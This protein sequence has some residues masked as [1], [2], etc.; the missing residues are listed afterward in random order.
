MPVDRPNE[1]RD[2]TAPRPR[3]RVLGPLADTLVWGVGLGV[4]VVS[5]AA[6][7]LIL[8][9]RGPG[10]TGAVLPLVN[11]AL[12]GVTNLRFEASRTLLLEQG[13]LLVRPRFS[14]VDSTGK[15]SPFFEADR[16]VVRTSWW[17]LITRRPDAFRVE[18]RGA[19]IL[20]VR[21]PDGS[22][23]LPT[24]RGTGRPPSPDARLD[25]DLRLD[26]LSLLARRG[27]GG[28]DSTDTL[29]AGVDGDVRISQRGARWELEFDG[30]RGRAPAAGLDHVRLGAEARLES[31]ALILRRVRL[32]SEGGWLA[33]EARGRVAPRTELTGRL[34]VG[35]VEW[36]R[37]AGWTGQEAL[38]VPGGLAG[39]FDFK[40]R[41]DSLTC[42]DALFDVLW[43][44]EPMSL[45]FLG[46]RGAGK[47]SLSG[48]SLRWGETEFH[49]TFDVA[50]DGVWLLDGRLRGLDLA[51]LPRV[52]PMPALDPSQLDADLVVGSNEDGIA[53]RVRRANGTWREFPVRNLEGTW[54]LTG[55][56]QSIDAVV[57]ALGGTIGAAGTI[58][59]RGIDMG[60]SGGDLS[61]A[62]LPAKTWAALGVSDPPAGRVESFE[63]RLSG[64]V[65]RPRARGAARISGVEVA[66]ARV[67]AADLLFDAAVGG[68]PE[69]TFAIEATD[70]VIGPSRADTASAHLRLA[71][72]TLVVESL[73]A[74]RGDSVLD[75]AG[76]AVRIGDAWD[77]VV[78]RASWDVGED[79]A[80]ES[81]GPVHVRFGPEGRIDVLR[82]HVLSN[83]GSFAAS[84]T[85]G[86]KAARNDLVLELE[87]LDLEAM[88][89]PFVPD[90]G[91]RGI[92]TGRARIEGTGDDAVYTVDLEG[93]ELR[94]RRLDA[95]RLVARGR[96]AREEWKVERLDLLTGRGRLG[97]TGDLVWSTAPPF[98]ANVDEWNAAL[99]AAPRWH[100]ELTA[101]SLAVE[102]LS[103]WVPQLGG[104]RGVLDLR[105]TLDGRPA[106]PT[107]RVTG[108]IRQ[109]GWG[110]ATL[111]DFDVDLE[112]KDELVTVRR[113]AMKGPEG[114]APRVTGTLPLRLG[115]GV[116][117]AER[118]PDR[119]MN[120][121]ATARNLALSIVP[122]ILPQVAAAGGTFDLDA[123]LTGTPKQPVLKGA[124]T[125]RDGV[126]R[127][128][129]REETFT[130]VEGRVVLD[131]SRLVVER[132]TAGQGKNG[133]I[134]VRP[135]GWAT[136]EDLHIVDYALDVDLTRI[137]A[138]SSGEYV[139]ELDAALK[140]EDGVDLGG[141][142]PLPH[143]TGMAE[144]REA[145]FL[146]NFADPT[147]AQTTQGPLVAPPWTF[148]IDVDAESNVWYR[149]TDAS[150]EGRLTDFRIIQ[151]LDK[152]LMLGEIEA[153][154]GTYYFLEN[155]FKLES[156]NLFF[157]AAQEM[158]PTVDATMTIEKP[159]PVS[160]ERETI[161]LTVTGR[162][163]SPTVTLTSS[164]SNL[165]QGDIVQL[166]TVGQLA[167]GGSA[168]V[169]AGS[170]YLARQLSRE[171]PELERY[172]GQIEVGTR[173]SEGGEEFASEVFTTVGVTRYF[174]RDLL[175]RYSQVVGDVSQTESVDYQ[176]LT[177]EYR[178]SRL[179]FL[180]G[181]VTRRRGVLITSQD[182]TIYNLDVRARHEY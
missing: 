63:A 59:P 18:A 168:L 9:S 14:L 41:G 171:V 66:E 156:G 101:D 36:T 55:D 124:I 160:G 12:S 128:A 181:Q 119:P 35:E 179:L 39:G 58:G 13:A 143:I 135:G 114:E 178:L 148:A 11:R 136:I 91:A 7:A 80:L 144:V 151:E 140:V 29:A 67:D 158:D 46:R 104:W 51:R 4:V 89:G 94:W 165:S 88:L 157:D 24:F 159:L 132:L 34:D 73:T 8:F 28:A 54:A 100:G 149:P 107:A 154:R 176:D 43:R 117:P 19:R 95:R 25:L 99:A 155:A 30:L 83:A 105:F 53:G 109:P 98:D 84:G 16:A 1:P 64:P 133:R 141:P 37:I 177:A 31:G 48:A 152:F 96:F 10:A 74:A 116:D 72:D 170:Q 49:G 169:S 122:L 142:L 127:P 40:V 90:A 134:V 5:V 182:Q 145:L 121:N 162:A 130:G 129:S 60:V 103:D 15:S 137:T 110:Q 146:Y 111:D 166:L 131:G 113:F 50:D 163:F 65:S 150:I 139:V 70:A 108:T 76:R 27:T 75:L 120:L 153:L 61:T 174:T 97:F 23:A 81:D 6:I 2:E 44:D 68:R 62:G 47:T 57:D 115:W 180:S 26:D 126:V 71:G 102:Q 164:P 56:L 82:A 33:A 147:R 79:L 87:T 93:R 85:W 17:G 78:D 92:V 161:T 69:G 172:L 118:L 77:V 20:L 52:W 138:F 86:G 42:E 175:V 106:E 32:E 112:Y 21:R 38:D 167:G 123:G 22:W 125:L 3:R 45:R 173:T